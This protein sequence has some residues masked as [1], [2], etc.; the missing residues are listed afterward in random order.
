MGLGEFL[1][2][3]GVNIGINI[4]SNRLDAFIANQMPTKE[5]AKLWL[6]T[7][8]LPSECRVRVSIAY[9]FRIQIDG[10]Y[11]LIKGKRVNQYQPVGGVRKWYDGAKKTFRDLGVQDDD[12]L[13]IDDD[14]RQD[15]RIR[16][17]A[18]NLLK[19]LGWYDTSEDREIE[20]RREF[21]EELIKPGFLSNELFATIRSSYLY[22][23]PTFHY[24]S[25]FQCQELLYHE[26]YDLLPST[27]QEQALRQ[28]Q[29][30]SSEEYKWVTEEAITMLGHDKRLGY[31]TFN[32]GEH[33]KL[34]ISK[35]HRLF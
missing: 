12:C 7:R 32:I 17:P 23:I 27:E 30:T 9:L 34:L 22:T 20:Q 24:S 13:P 10:Q 18:R 8:K 6:I 1:I 11:L 25:H 4:L 31:K 14:S 26:V 3:T 35:K 33:S 21:Y 5:R 19:L 2:G 29:D 15:L 28:L 16:V